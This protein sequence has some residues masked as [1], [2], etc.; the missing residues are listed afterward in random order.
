[1]NELANKRVIV[2]GAGAS[3]VSAALL[4]HSK[5][6]DVC[7]VD[8]GSGMRLDD[9]KRQLAPTGIRVETGW[10]PTNQTCECDL[11]IISPGVP[12]DSPMARHFLDKGVQM[13]SELEF[14]SWFC[15]VPKLAITGTNG[16]TTVVEMLTH[17]L[18][19]IG[20]RV[21]ACGNIGLP[22]SQ[23]AV[24]GADEDV[25][26]VEVSSYQLETTQHFASQAAAL[27]NI[28]PDHLSR[29]HT[30]EAYRDIKL[31]LLQQVADGGV[32][33]LRKDLASEPEIINALYGKRLLTFTS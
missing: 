8:G 22:L 32:C 5:G 30:M 13:V 17:C 33:V 21:K 9:T 2:L 16:K 26:V 20:K 7:L 6:A 12:A 28:T 27:L 25:L 4:A 10:Q 3:G 24:D 15:N 11:C 31:K 18:E 19:G 14:G 29:H 1:M 23:V